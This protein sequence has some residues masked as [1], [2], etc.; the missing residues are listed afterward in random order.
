MPAPRGVHL[1]NID[2]SAGHEDPQHLP[3]GGEAVRDVP[4]AEGDPHGVKTPIGERKPKRVRLE[5]PDASGKAAPH[6]LVYPRGEHL[7]D[8]VDPRHPDL[9]M[10]SGGL[11]GQIRRS[12]RHVEKVE[13]LKEAHLPD[14]ETSPCDVA[15]EAQEAVQEVVAPGDRREDL[16]DHA[17]MLVAADRGNRRVVVTVCFFAGGVV[18]HRGSAF[19]GEGSGVEGVETVLSRRKH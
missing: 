18:H 1:E 17:D 9:R 15:A 5:K 10:P 13:G 6:D 8:E 11:D 7:G 16:P 2:P 19:I 12:G 3:K 14:G 4:D